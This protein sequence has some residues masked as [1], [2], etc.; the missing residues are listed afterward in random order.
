VLQAVAEAPPVVFAAAVAE[1]AVLPSLQALRPCPGPEEQAATVLQVV[2]RCLIAAAAG[3]RRSLSQP[4]PP[5]DSAIRSQAGLTPQLQV[6]QQQQQVGS[7]SSAA[8][9]VASLPSP[10]QRAR[11]LGLL[12]REE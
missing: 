9:A 10:S 6:Q 7:W 5:L 12:G 2:L 3:S 8:V 1:L 11:Q 4:A